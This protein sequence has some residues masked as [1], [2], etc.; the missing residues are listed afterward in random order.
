MNMKKLLVKRKIVIIIY[1]NLII[2]HLEEK[3]EKY[4]MLF[5]YFNLYILNINKIFVYYKYSN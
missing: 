3:I 5:Y 4:K 1:L 2:F